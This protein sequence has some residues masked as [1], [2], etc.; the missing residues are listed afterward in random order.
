MTIISNYTAPTRQDIVQAYKE[1]LE[2]LPTYRR[3][4]N[5]LERSL[6]EIQ[7]LLGIIRPLLKEPLSRRYHLGEYITRGTVYSA[8]LEEGILRELI[9]K[10][11]FDGTV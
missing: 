5:A 4:L 11:R 9:E 6:K 8:Q 10:L 1:E 3:K 2:T 7:D